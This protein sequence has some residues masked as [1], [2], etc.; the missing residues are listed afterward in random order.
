M[1]PFNTGGLTVFL[2]ISYVQQTP[3]L[4]VSGPH[5]NTNLERTTQSSDWGETN[6]MVLNK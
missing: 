6:Q 4:F 3:K 5:K 2:F 1:V